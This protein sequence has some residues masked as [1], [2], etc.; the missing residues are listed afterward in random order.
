MRKI[1]KDEKRK[2]VF[3]MSTESE[4]LEIYMTDEPRSF[5]RI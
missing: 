5:L 4:C 3:K 2:H 1:G